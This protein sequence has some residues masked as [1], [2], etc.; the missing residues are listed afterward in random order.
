M[1]VA[2]LH[3]RETERLEDLKSFSILDTNSEDH[4]DLVTKLVSTICGTEIALVSLVDDQ[5]Q[6]FKSKVGLDV[7]E[8]NRDISFCS[9]ALLGTELLEV[10]DAH[11]DERFFD[12]PLVLDGPKIR[13]YAGVPLISSRGLPFGTLCAIDSRP[14]TLTPDQK[15]SLKFLANHVV[16]FIE[17][18]N[19]RKPSH[20]DVQIDEA[21][22]ERKD[23]LIK[24][25]FFLIGKDAKSRLENYLEGTD[26]LNLDDHVLNWA[27]ELKKEPYDLSEFVG[28]LVKL[29]KPAREKKQA[30]MISNIKGGISSEL[31]RHQLS[32]AIYHLLRSSQYCFNEAHSEIRLTTVKATLIDKNLT[33]EFCHNGLGSIDASLPYRFSKSEFKTTG[34]IWAE[35][36]EAYRLVLEL[37]GKMDISKKDDHIRCVLEFTNV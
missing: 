29:T 19:H 8:T 10:G 21:L 33:L 5:R 17:S 26:I 27:K 3:P 20:N 18:N 6:W 12:N 22:I 15:K 37:G 23:G 35:L 11:K 24:D 2:N 1:K 14:K 30:L 25:A 13:F 31:N 7:C 32:N 34:P 16:A 9:H 36:N 4:F 28:N